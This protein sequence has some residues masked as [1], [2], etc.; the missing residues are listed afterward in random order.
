MIALPVTALPIAGKTVRRLVFEQHAIAPLLGW[1]AYAVVPLT[2]MG[3]AAWGVADAART[4]RAEGVAVRRALLLATW[5]FLCLNFAFVDY[6]WPWAAWTN[7]TLHALVFLA[8]AV[9]VSVHAW[10]CGRAK[11]RSI[12]SVPDTA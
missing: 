9:A 11:G 3:L 1:L 4:G 12:A 5:V 2:L 7:R 10:G 8:C 6:P